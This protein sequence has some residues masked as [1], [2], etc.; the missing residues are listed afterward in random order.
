MA[1]AM[2]DRHADARLNFVRQHLPARSLQI[3]PA[4]ADASFRSYWRARTGANSWIV[5]DA[6]PDKENIAPWLDIGT[7]LRG[8]G[9]HTP[10]VFAVDAAQGFILMEDLGTRAY[11]PELNTHTAD[12]LYTEA[13]EALIAMQTRVSPLSL[14]AFDEAF[15]IMELEIMPT[16]FLERH[17]GYTPTC[18]EWDAIELAFRC[19]IHSARQ[20]PQVFMHRDFHSRNL[21]IVEHANPATIAPELLSPGIID[22]QGAVLG[23]ITYDLASLLRDC[24][25]AWPIEQIDAWVEQYRQHL[26]SVNAIDVDGRQFRRWFDLI[27]LQRHIKVLGLFSRLNYRDAKSGYLNDLPLVIDYVLKVARLYPELTELAAVIE[28]AVGTRD[29]TQARNEGSAAVA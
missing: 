28:R 22:F 26:I 20:Q 13:L 8:A 16:W 17:L 24:Y 1:F 23:P 2:P 5:M 15:L 25:V 27:G 10:E 18:G 11:L 7:R 19:L 14:P 29:I 4:S 6:P 9:L 3:E 12:K 21:M